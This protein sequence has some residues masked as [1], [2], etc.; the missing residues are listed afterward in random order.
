V[1]TL[2]DNKILPK[3]LAAIN[4]VG[5]NA[6][7]KET[8][9]TYDPT[10]GATSE[11]VT[12]NHTIKIVPPA[13]LNIQLVNGEVYKEGDMVTYIAGSGAVVIPI[14]G[15][16]VTFDSMKFQ[17]VTANPLYSGDDI[18]AWELVLRR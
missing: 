9:K 2:L 8:T 3:V 6:T 18:A 15:M 10:T 17:I 7:F 11:S 4:K 14:N 12:T 1:S 5:T 13:P 16:E